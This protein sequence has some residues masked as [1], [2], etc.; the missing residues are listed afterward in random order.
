MAAQKQSMGDLADSIYAMNE[1]IAAA[2][3]VTENLRNERKALEV[4]LMGEMEGQ[5]LDQVRGQ[6]ATCSLGKKTRYAIQDFDDFSRFV[7]R[8]KALYLF[9]KRP[10]QVAVKELEEQMGKP[11]PGLQPFTTQSLNVRKRT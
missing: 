1:S 5:G 3:A 9:E 11:I 4:R 8:R 2:D 7:L 6:I 10:A